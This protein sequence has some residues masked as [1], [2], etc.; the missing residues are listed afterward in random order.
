MRSYKFILDCSAIEN[1][2]LL[3]SRVPDV[4]LSLLLH[5]LHAGISRIYDNERCDNIGLTI[6]S[7]P[8]DCDN[9]RV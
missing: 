2:T 8:L 3:F 6:I 1:R 5:V 4:K 7:Q 9:P